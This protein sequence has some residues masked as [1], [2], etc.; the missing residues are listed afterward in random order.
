MKGVCPPSGEP[1]GLCSFSSRLSQPPP[2]RHLVLKVLALRDKRVLKEEEEEG[3]VVGRSEEEE[4][5][6]EGPGGGGGEVLTVP[7]TRRILLGY[8]FPSTEE[9]GDRG[10]EAC[11]GARQA[12]CSLTSSPHHPFLPAGHHDFPSPRSNPSPII[13][14]F[15]L[16]FAHLIQQV[17]SCF[18]LPLTNGVTPPPSPLS[19]TYTS[20]HPQ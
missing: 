15:Q 2:L 13:A 16:G 18:I 6:R 5:G 1:C 8:S 20:I 10:K 7:P 4:K 11:C 19:A 3:E 12:C 9:R 14:S 17:P